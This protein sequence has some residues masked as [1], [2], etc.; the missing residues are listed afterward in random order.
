[1]GKG[2]TLVDE[3]LRRLAE[4]GLAIHPGKCVFG[5]DKLEFLGWAVS[6][7]GISP[8]PKKVEAI[9]AFPAP[10]TQKDLLG[11]LGALNYYRRCLPSIEGK[12]PA[13]I[14]QPLYTA[15]TKKIPGK[16][17][18]TMWEEENL[19]THFQKAK[20]MLAMACTLTYPDPAAP[21]ALTTDSS[22]HSIGGVLEQF[23]AGIWRPLGFWSRNL[24]QDK[25]K[26]STYR[27]ETF[28]V[29]QGLR[30]FHDE[31]AG[32][33]VVVFTDHKPLVQAFKAPNPPN[34]DVIAQQHLFEISQWTNDVRFIAGK[35]NI[36]AD[37]LSRPP[38]VPEQRLHHGHS[39][40]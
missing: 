32:R 14:L 20:D 11:F 5:V 1:M 6:R 27:R 35:S 22:G 2:L 21:I 3:L 26:W 34:H 10:R 29:Q 7:T 4:A 31:I 33:D 23:E 15:A 9:R 36:V 16:T 8:L 28:A 37:M 17:F 13:D 30:H 40:H 19:A 12:K 25:R 18:K 39:S 24:P 38:D